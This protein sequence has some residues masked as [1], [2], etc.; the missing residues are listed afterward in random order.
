MWNRRVEIYNI[1]GDER[2]LLFVGD[3][4]KPVE[5]RPCVFPLVNVGLVDNS[6][7]YLVKDLLAYF[8]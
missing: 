4:D 5:S 1:E 8:A 7:V 3:I 6:F 2:V